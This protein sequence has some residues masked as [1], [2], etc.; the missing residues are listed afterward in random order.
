MSLFRKLTETVSKGVSTATE[1]AQQTVEITRLHAQM[2]AKRKEIDN[3]MEE[4]GRMVYEG[5][6]AGDPLQERARVEGVCE[7]IR[8]KYREIT[9]IENRIMELRNEKECACGKKVAYDARFCPY[10]GTPFPEPLTVTEAE[11]IEADQA[12][13]LFLTDG[14]SSGATCA[15]PE[16]ESRE[17]GPSSSSGT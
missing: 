2:A 17:D 7:Q 11:A 6:L 9:A 13:P 8:S 5:Y 10:C 12:D 15:T 4:I 14:S 1:K 3:L 16:N